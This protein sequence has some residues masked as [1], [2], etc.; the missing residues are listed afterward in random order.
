V[1]LG[2]TEATQVDFRVD[3]T[4]NSAG[5]ER[6][7]YGRADIPVVPLAARIPVTE[8][9]IT[10]APVATDRT[11]L[12][13]GRDRELR[14][15]KEG[16]AGGRLR[17]LYFVNGIRRV[18][19]SSLMAHLGRVC[20][21]DV[22]TLVLDFEVARQL[23][24]VQM[25]R[26][27][28]RKASIALAR[29]PGFEHI[30]LPLP[31][32]A[33]FELDPAW[34][35]F[36][37]ALRGLQNRA[38]RQ[39]LVC[40]DELQVLVE[41]VANPGEPIGDSV[42]SW[43]REKAQTESDLLFICTGSESFE[44]TKKRYEEGTRLWGNVTPY[45]V[46]FV[47]QKAMERIVTNPLEQDGVTWLP[48]SLALLWDLT[49]GHPWVTQI[50]GEQVATA[51]NRERRRVVVPGDVDRAADYALASAGVS[52]LWWN[53]SEGVVTP[54]HRQVAFLILQHQ[55]A[56]RAGV[57]TADLVPV[58]LR[59]GIR[60]PGRYTEE[61]KL[62]ELVTEDSAGPDSRLRI[63]GGL[64]ERY[65]IGLM[66]Q[67]M[68]EAT[69]ATP[70]VA[71]QPLG[72][73][74]DVENIKKSLQ[75]L[76]EDKPPKERDRLEPRLR[77]DLLGARLLKAAGKHGVPRLKWAVANW[78]RGFLRG[79]QMRYKQ[80]GF[81]PDLAGEDKANASD[82]VLRER[83]HDALRD[84]PDINGF[85]VGSG[86]G[87]FQQVIE[88]LQDKNK[89]VVLWATRN[90][91]SRAFGANLRGPNSIIIEWLED[92]VFEEN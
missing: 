34:T 40:F 88:T 62:L 82:H 73:F 58:C 5:V 69:S 22:L 55:P 78:D 24:D 87:D 43:L 74:L 90:N 37:N 77:G 65:L 38:G 39:I 44:T 32:A 67:A 19:K 59:A 66:T 28:L 18:G 45:D 8:R 81:Q 53:E 79:E 11:D 1:E 27:L 85:V 15:L 29:T 16:F 71:T 51:L 76:L 57:L 52:D 4:Y 42:L 48:E 49:E 61:M 89:Y 12:F 84:H 68:N 46:S 2:P 20:A 63:R 36:E 13:H 80:A 50:L 92:L 10:G 21:P 3:V 72:I 56:P 70:A 9:F 54:E 64:L 14:E 35:V 23:N 60:S 41:R 33:D 30:E 17:R 31:G 75:E 25:V 7:V 86:D 6:T 47:D 91:S 83:I 26:A